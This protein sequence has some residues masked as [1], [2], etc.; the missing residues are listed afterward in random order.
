MEGISKSITKKDHYPK[1]SGSA[2]YVA[3]YPQEGILYGKLLH[4]TK[5]KA[6]ILNITIPEIPEGYYVVDKKDVPGEN[7]VHIVMD[8]TP[9]FAEDTVEYIGDPILMVVGPCEKEVKRILNEIHVE[10][11]ELTPILNMRDYDTVF[12]DYNYGKGDVEKAF[13]EADEVFCEE[14]ETGYQEQAYLEPQGLMA[15]YHDGKITVQG[16]MQCPYYVHGAVAKALGFEASKVQIK[17]DVT[18]GGFGGKEDFPSILACQVA[19]AAI[20]AGKPVRVIFDRREDMEFTSKRHPSI[21]TYKA[22]VKDGKVTAMDIDVLFNGGAYTT[23]SAV[24]LQR[25]IICSSGVY[26]V[27]NLKV[28]GRAVKTNTVPNGAYR[29]FGAPQTFFSVETLMNHIADKLGID[30]LEFKVNNMVKQ[31]DSTSTGGRYHF[32][33][34]LPEMIEEVDK[35][36]DYR[37]KRELYKGEQTGRYRRGIGM[38]L[39]FHGA[40]FTGSGERDII[41]AV[42]KLHKY[43]D[44]RVEVLAS[45]ADIGQGLRTTFAK[46]AANELNIPLD[47]IIVENPDTDRVPD[48]GPTVASRSLMTV[49][50]LIR[51]A[52]IKLRENWIEGEDQI[53]EEHFKEPDF[54]IPFYLD[55]FQGDAYPTYAW[56]VVAV[57]VEVDT[58]TGMNKVLSA[59]GS[60]DVGT[61]IDYN[62][63]VGQMEGGFMQGLG[64]SSMEHMSTDSRGRIR[65]NSY[66]DYIIPTAVDVPVLK[67]MLHVEKYPLGPYGAKGAGEL[68]LVGIPGAYIQ[69]MEQALKGSFNTTPFTM[70]H[71]M[72]YL[73]RNK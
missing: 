11:Q 12:F 61:P 54:V 73:R 70:E 5:A 51:R 68:P 50:E 23:L 20:K 63:V 45:N 40:G 8:D 18:G 60:F 31:G 53:I 58:L 44:G 10:Y 49:G 14:F 26:K 62:I 22:A 41:K 71:T 39:F 57:E 56:G 36:S 13:L 30:S 66:S 17:M 3:D 4:S 29:G 35:A 46:I 42:L 16:S 69:A 15:E 59:I 33:V 47:R 1:I 2:I 9:V 43:P 32:P 27:D 7:R 6:K 65:N 34:P 52:A 24:V 19:V 28:R 55:K 25:G 72:N 37:N 21:C 64:Y 38:S 48:S 67:A